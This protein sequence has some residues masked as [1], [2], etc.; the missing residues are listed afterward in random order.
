MQ[1]TLSVSRRE[2]SMELCVPAMDLPAIGPLDLVVYHVGGDDGSGPIG[3]LFEIIPNAILVTFE[4][5]D[6]ANPVTVTGD[7]TQQIRIKVNRGVDDGSGTK[8]FYVTNHP[9]SSSLLKPASIALGEDPGLPFCQTWG[10]NTRIEKTI[11]VQTSS[12]EQIIEEFGLPPPDVISSDA[13]GAELRILK[14]AGRHLDNALGVVTEVEFSEIYHRQAL[15]DDQMSFLMPKGFRLVNLLNAQVWHPFA[16]T[17]GMGFLTVGE[18]LWVKFFHAFTSDDDRP[19]RGY[20]DIDSASIIT[21]LKACK[22]AM[23][24][25]MISYAVKIAKYVETERNDYQEHVHLDPV[26]AR[27]FAILRTVEAHAHN[28]D[29]PLDFYID[30]IQ[31]PGSDFLR[32]AV[33]G[34]RIAQRSEKAR[35]ALFVYGITLYENGDSESA[36]EICNLVLAGDPTHFGARHLLS[37]IAMQSGDNAGAIAFITQ[38]LDMM[39]EHKSYAGAYSNRGIARARLGH[40]DEAIADFDKA[41]SLAGPTANFLLHRAN[42]FLNLR[43]FAEALRDYDKVIELEKG[44]EEAHYHRGLTLAL[45][46]RRTEAAESLQKCLRLNPDSADIKAKLDELLR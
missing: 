34:S 27:A 10:E 1:P 7:E 37:I 24:F 14:G 22:I 18:A 19:A 44:N 42:H 13:Q 12:L 40:N 11:S 28:P 16:R 21:L 8:E 33:P 20:A 6:D 46:G 2:A 26:L 32:N 30:A 4:I 43:R 38:A 3:A 31:F 45:L 25:R 35:Q 39:P 5:R 9:K 29:R 17:P 23:G 15:F 36:R 41:I